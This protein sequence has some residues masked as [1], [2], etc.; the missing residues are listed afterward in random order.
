MPYHSPSVAAVLCGC[1]T[2]SERTLKFHEQAVCR[3]EPALDGWNRTELR[4]RRP[5]DGWLGVTLKRDDLRED[6]GNPACGVMGLQAPAALPLPARRQH[7]H[8][9]LLPLEAPEVRKIG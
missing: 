4:L 8:P 2:E 9:P 3:R 7:L 6:R 5:V 1:T